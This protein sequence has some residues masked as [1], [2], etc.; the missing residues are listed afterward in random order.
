MT[1]TTIIITALE[2]MKTKIK[3]RI[4]K[5]KVQLVTIHQDQK[6]KKTAL[7]ILQTTFSS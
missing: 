4:I 1:I 5:P 3:K 6:R 2:K 7:K